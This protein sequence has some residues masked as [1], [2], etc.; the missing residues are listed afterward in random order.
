M[1]A[2]IRMESGF[3]KPGD[4]IYIQGPTTGSIDLII[5][6]IRVDLKA[7]KKTIKGDQCSIPVD[8]FLRRADKVYKIINNTK[9]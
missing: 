8:T 9:N 7:V 5:P 4:A 6:E 3:L 2:E 1:V